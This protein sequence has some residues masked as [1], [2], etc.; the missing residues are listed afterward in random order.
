MDGGRY[1]DRIAVI[2]RSRLGRI[3]RRTAPRPLASRLI[4][5][6]LPPTIANYRDHVERIFVDWSHTPLRELAEDPARVA[7]K[8]DEVSK[9]HGP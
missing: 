8:H 4:G 2:R 3:Q 7:A 6:G 9:T 5:K 1:C